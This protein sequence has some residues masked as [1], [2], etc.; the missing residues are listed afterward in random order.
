MRPGL[1]AALVLAAT[2]TA[3]ATPEPVAL[4]PITS[5][6]IAAPTQSET[7]TRLGALID[8]E[9]RINDVFGRLIT[10]NADLCGPDFV[11][12]FGFKLWSIEDFEPAMRAAASEALGLDE[13][14]QVYAVGAGLPAAAAGVKPG[15]IL[16]RVE[17]RRLEPGASGRLQFSAGVTEGLIKRGNVRFEFERDGKRRKARL[18]ALKSCPFSA[19]LAVADEANA[20]TDG[21]TIFVTTGML[22]FA[23]DDRELALVLGHEIA[24][25]I[26]RHPQR[27]AR[28]ES[29]GIGGGLVIDSVVTAAVDVTD[30]AY[31][32][33][34]SMTGTRPNSILFEMEAD[35]MGMYLTARAGYDVSNAAEIWTRLEATYPGASRGSWTHPSNSDRFEAMNRTAEE[36]AEKR[37]AGRDLIPDAPSS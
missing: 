36:I 9:R 2:L 11:P 16:T 27:S 13:R 25:A 22:R 1:L 21:K 5:A 37:A 15:D 26:R 6:A 35:Y 3:C 28:P 17:G 12:A 24:H 8:D 20:A 31:A 10:S 18:N 23:R 14:L 33:V 34:K 30:A 29:S 19:S 7:A 32:T 4:V